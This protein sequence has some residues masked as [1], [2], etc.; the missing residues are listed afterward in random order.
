[1]WGHK[2]GGGR[3]RPGAPGSV[4]NNPLFLL[5]DRAASWGRG[6][7]PE[8]ITWAAR[9]AILDWF[10]T[11][12]PGCVLPPATRLAAALDDGRGSGRAVSYVDG[13]RCAPRHAALINAVA[14]HTVEFDDI[15]RD[16]GYHPGSSTVAAA[17]ALAQ[18]RG[19][20]L[21]VLHGAI[22][23]GYE[24][25]C[26]ISLA[27]QPSHYAFWHTTSTI[28]TIGAAVAG[29]VVLGCD[30]QRIAHAIALASSFAGGHQQN[31]E[32]E[33][34]AK[35]MHPGHAAD[36]GLLAALAAAN[37]VTGAMASLDGSKGFAAA[38]STSRGDWAAALDGLGVWTPITRMTIKAHGCCGHI[39]PALDG[40]RVMRAAYGFEPDDIA[41]VHVDGYSAT[42]QMCDR[43]QAATASDARFSIQFCMA[44]QIVLGSVRLEAFAPAALENPRIRALMPKITVSEDEALAAAYPRRRMA[45][46]TVRLKDGRQLEHFQTTRKGDPEEPLTDAELIAKFDELACSVVAP[47][48][49]AGLRENVLHGDEL[50][51][52]VPLIAAAS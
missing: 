34:M 1:M 10:A 16:G 28:G 14:S 11:T 9:R 33:G 21:A 20:S 22:V 36:A 25:G 17:L 41:A 31:L 12:L 24:V 2:R 44:A 39:F 3:R 7:L 42:R 40:L 19:A 43:P 52:Q 49:A 13:I 50:P 35:A 8:P 45:R 32:G 5:A 15:F 29:A 26:R 47:Q 6:A 4:V 18:H 51:G 38:T 30:V 46:L 27:V 37:G 23:A 48:I